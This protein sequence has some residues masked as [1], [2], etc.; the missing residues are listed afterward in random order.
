LDRGLTLLDFVREL[1]TDPNRTRQVVG[2][3]E[4]I[5]RVL[6]IDLER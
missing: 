4:W 2:I 3:Y 5:P 1:A 6:S